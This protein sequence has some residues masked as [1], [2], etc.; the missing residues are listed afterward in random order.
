M[1]TKL[2]LGL[3]IAVIVI[4]TVVFAQIPI[5]ERQARQ[6]RLDK[7]ELTDEQESKIQDLHLALQKEILPMTSKIRSL[8]D[9][10]KQEMIAEKFNQSKVKGLIEQKEQIRT[11]IQFKR[12]LNQRAVREILT[13]EQQKKFD[14]G[15][16]RMGK[17][18][19]M[20]F[21]GED[22]RPGRPMRMGMDQPEPEAPLPDREQ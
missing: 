19:G 15:V 10:I 11:E 22:R 16:L 4:A 5:K 12:A 17:R 8:G 7:L 14:L 21:H 1:K 9:E 13:P 3:A 6:P 2:S 18:M 20:R